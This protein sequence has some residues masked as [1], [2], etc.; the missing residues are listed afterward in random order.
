MDFIFAVTVIFLTN[1]HKFSIVDLFFSEQVGINMWLCPN[2]WDIYMAKHFALKWSHHLMFL[3]THI[4]HDNCSTKKNIL[5]I[6]FEFCCHETSSCLWPI[7]CSDFLWFTCSPY[8]SRARNVD[9]W[10]QLP[11]LAIFLTKDT[12]L[13]NTL[14]VGNIEHNSNQ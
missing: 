9:D 8:I 7:S 2:F 4:V 10:V 12:L 11:I 1:T 3:L 6:F 13:A 5:Y 14:Y